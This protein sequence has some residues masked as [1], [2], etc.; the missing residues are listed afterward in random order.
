MIKIKD[1]IAQLGAPVLRK[2]AELIQNF[3]A[4][5]TMVLIDKMLEILSKSNGVGLAAP[6]IFES[7]AIIIVA[8]KPSA[9][10]PKAPEMQPIVMINPEYR[11]VS[12]KQTTD[13]EGCLSIPGIRARVPRYDQIEIT[14]FDRQG[15]QKNMQLNGF[16]ARI[17]Q[18]EFDH[19]I[20]KVYL[21]RVKDNRDIISELEFQKLM[22]DR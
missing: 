9:R 2:Q 3:E 20:G 15:K 17:F 14:F 13:W 12:D 6:Q 21:D 4:E 7:F 1:Q 11:A 22:S 8:S 10:Y 18:H 5:K 16:V 19:L